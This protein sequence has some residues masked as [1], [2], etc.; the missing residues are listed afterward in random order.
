MRAGAPKSLFPG[1][2][3]SVASFARREGRA[4]FEQERL[5][6]G[7]AGSTMP[8]AWTDRETRRFSPGQFHQGRATGEVSIASAF[9]GFTGSCSPHGW[10]FDDRAS[11]PPFKAAGSLHYLLRGGETLTLSGAL[12]VCVCVFVCVCVCVCVSARRSSK[13]QT[14]SEAGETE[15]EKINTKVKQSTE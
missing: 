14:K 5:R 9:S 4:E 6:W 7:T 10:P 12:C 3:G 1:S 8:L 2:L 13:R 15:K 11:A